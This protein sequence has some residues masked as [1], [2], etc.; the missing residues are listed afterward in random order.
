MYFYM[1]DTAIEIKSAVNLLYII[2]DFIN[3]MPHEIIGNNIALKAPPE[4]LDLYVNISRVAFHNL[5]INIFKLGE[6]IEKNQRILGNTPKFRKLANEFRSKFFTKDLRFYRNTY[7][8]H[9]S[10][11][12]KGT[13]G[14]FLNYEEL[15]ETFCKIISIDIKLLQRDI[16]TVFPLLLQYGENFYSKEN[17]PSEIFHIII[18]SQA[19]FKEILSV[20]ELNRKYK[21]S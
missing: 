13:S 21:F 6:L 2:K 18:N 16:K 3:G 14:E 10:N 4:P 17:K 9:H 5:I 15:T 12:Q 19:E 20:A 8:A 11:N 7:V 1:Q